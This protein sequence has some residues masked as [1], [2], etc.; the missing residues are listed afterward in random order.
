MNKNLLIGLV[1]GAVVIFIGYSFMGKSD[2]P[3]TG[4]TMTETSDTAKAEAGSFNGSLAELAARGGSWKCTTDITTGPSV[5]SG[6][7]YSSGGKVR[8]D[9]STKV[10]GYGNIDSHM[11]VDGQDVY[12]WSSVMKQGIKTKMSPLGA[13]T[14]TPTSGQS[15]DTNQQYSYDCQPWTADLSLF[16]TP[17]G[18]T[19]NTISK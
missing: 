4:G 14:Q 8:G 15:V 17:P 13:V 2:G 5:T 3:A 9:F 16:A 11:Y 12:T 19:F 6:V 10:Q 7:T 18:I 1:A